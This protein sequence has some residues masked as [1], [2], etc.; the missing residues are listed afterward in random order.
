VGELLLRL[1]AITDAGR[2]QR[3]LKMLK[4]DRYQLFMDVTDEHLVGIVKSQTGASSFYSTRLH[5]SGDYGCCRHDLETCM[6]LQG[7]ICKHLLVLALGAVQAGEIDVATLDSWLAK[8]ARKRPSDERQEASDTILRY[9]SAE[10]GELDWRPTET[11]PEDF[12]AY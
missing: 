1:R 7:R 9:R 5:A 8:A 3:A 4:A 6:G 10:A 2:L 11:T 12:Y